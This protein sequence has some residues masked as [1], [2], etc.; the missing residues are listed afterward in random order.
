VAGAAAGVPHS[1]IPASRIILLRRLA[2][3]TTPPHHAIRPPPPQSLA[4]NITEAY[5]RLEPFLRAAV[6]SFVREHL[7]T[8]AENEDG[9]DK[10]F[11]LSFYGLP[12]NDKLRSLRS[13]KIGKLSQFVG[14]VTRTTD[15]RPE[16]FTGTFRCME[17]MTGGRGVGVGGCSGLC[18]VRA[19]AA[20]AAGVD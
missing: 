3:P 9:S 14:T 1:A 18:G 16:L 19:V 13:A 20:A 11:W 6:R 12:D 17:C 4:A 15:V 5:Y 8:F 2:H 10:Q 7:D